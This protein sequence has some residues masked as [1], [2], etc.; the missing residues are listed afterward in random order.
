MNSEYINT[1]NKYAGIYS[2]DTYPVHKTEYLH[3]AP[4]TI[5]ILYIILFSIYPNNY[6]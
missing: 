5:I 6:Y 1:D 2:K 4:M 3:D